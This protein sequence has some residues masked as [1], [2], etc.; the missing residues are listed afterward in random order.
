MSKRKTRK[1]NNNSA[2]ILKYIAW[3]L[4]VIAL[5]LSSVVA[6]Y[7]FGYGDGSSEVSKHEKQEIKN[8]LAKKETS[9]LKKKPKSVN[10]RLREVLKKEAKHEYVSADHELDY[11]KSAVIPKAAKKPVVLTAS[12]P[13][14]AII[15][16]DVSTQKHVREIDGLGLV[17]TKSFLPPSAARPTTPKLAANAKYYMVH[18]PLEA[19]SFS[20]E[21]PHT[22]RIT[23]TQKTISQRIKKIKQWFPRVQYINNHTGSKF[24]SDEVAMNKLIYA[25]KNNNISFVDSRTTAATMAP[26]VLK[27]FGLKYVSRD[28]F[29]DHEMDIPYVRSQIKKA[30]KFAKVH[31]SAIAI[32]HPHPNTLQALRE[33]KKLFKDVDLVYIYQI[34]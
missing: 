3:V 4:A 34:Y 30:I 21:E 26:K 15:I 27:N 13:K 17:L 25:L 32:G 6:G 29:L 18:L 31:G 12:K 9:R 16:D 10:K 8:R 20:A 22:L 1:K 11:K 5:I 28:V 14:L 24:T 7:Y 2:K 33:S 23:D 19:L